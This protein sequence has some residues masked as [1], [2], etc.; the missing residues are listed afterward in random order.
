MNALRVQENEFSA[1]SEWY[2]SRTC[3]SQIMSL[4]LY[5]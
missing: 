3:Y 4:V 1:R 2:R 5:Q